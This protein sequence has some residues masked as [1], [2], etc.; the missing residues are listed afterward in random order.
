MKFDLIL[1]NESEKA[2]S[3]DA[4]GRGGRKGTIK[5]SERKQKLA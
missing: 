2:G 3:W 5:I 1:G 4:R